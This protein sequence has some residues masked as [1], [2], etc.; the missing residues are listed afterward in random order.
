MGKVKSDITTLGLFLINNLFLVLLN[1]I[2]VKGK[3]Q[4]FVFLFSE[5]SNFNQNFHLQGNWILIVPSAYKYR[6]SFKLLNHRPHSHGTL[7]FKK[8]FF[9]LSLLV[10]RLNTIYFKSA[11]SFKPKNKI[12]V[13]FCV[14]EID[15]SYLLFNYYCIFSSC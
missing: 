6:L 7:F 2:Y 9:S 13:M 12:K 11:R 4:I 1:F 14:V 15:P 8:S 10:E 5:M 3:F